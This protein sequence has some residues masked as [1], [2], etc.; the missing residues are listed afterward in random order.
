MQ[1]VL[2][3]GGS[4][5]RL[6]P[7]SNNA[8]SKQFL[9][10]LEKEDGTMESMVQRVVRQARK[11]NL[12]NDITLATNASQQDII[13]NQL[14]DSVNLVTEPERR[15]TFP[16]I[17]LAA[18]YLKLAKQCDDDEVVVI[19]PCDPYTELGYFETIGKM[20]ECVKANVADL[21]LMGI[22][23]TY[24]SEKYGYV[25][26][27]V[28]EV[29][30]GFKGL[31]AEPVE[32]QMVSRFTEK[33]TTS[34]AEELLKQ[35]AFWNGGVFAFRLGY[36]MNIVR[37]YM[38]IADLSNPSNNSNSSNQE[39]ADFETVRSRYSEFPKISFDYEVAEK[40][41]S[42]AVVPFNGE[43]RDL[44]TWN[45]LTD[46]LH[47]PVI[48]NAVMGA[49]CENT[50]VINELQNPIFVDGLKDVVV[51][52]CPDGILVCSKEHSEEIKKSVE[53]LTPRPMYEERR[54]GTYRVLD[55]SYYADGRH[56]LT[57][58]ITLKEG[59]NISYQIH[60]H[61]SETWTFVQ[62]VGIFVLDGQEQRVKAGDTVVIPVEHWH[63]IKALSELTFIEV[64]S[65]NPL[66]EEDIERTEWKWNIK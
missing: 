14:G 5:K 63:A 38:P 62:G 8:R 43:W 44:G 2:L 52:A 23:P 41:E 24:P 35:G 30:D 16:A 18:S 47:K 40:A 21:V 39:I 50:H 61:R 45:T 66:I 3:S 36:M 19:M 51:A 37:K 28:S 22:K 4:G 60:H 64:Q 31:V 57:K 55:D 20:V 26:P 6:W 25:V 56:S 7:L 12:T 42:V 17:A 48:G 49:H 33:P 9:P 32:V 15:D 34:V 29:S 10:L 13:V 1:L 46:E 54:W 59:K 58:S 53:N 27:K 11:A 65:G